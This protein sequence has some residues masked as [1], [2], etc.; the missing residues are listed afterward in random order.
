MTDQVASLKIGVDGSDAK[1]GINEIKDAVHGIAVEADKASQATGKIGT[2]AVASTDKATAAT[3]R[4]EAQLKRLN[5][6]L[7]AGGKNTTAYIEGRAKLA[8][9]DVAALAPLIKRNQELRDVQAL[10][11]AEFTKSGKA[12]TEY[13]MGVKATSAALR[14]V[15]AQFTDIIVSLQG[16]QA[17]LT[18][19][20][21]QGGQLKDV[22]GGVGNAFKA[23]SSYV[24]GLVNPFTIAAGVAATL[25]AAFYKG[26]AESEAY[27]KSLILT[28]NAAG[29]TAGRL[30]TMA[31]SVSEASGNTTA[32]VAS[33]MAQLVSAGGVAEAQFKRIA[34]TAASFERVAGVAV[35]ETVKQF[36]ELGKDPVKASEKLNESTHYLTAEI[37]NQIKALEDQGDKLGAAAVAQR[38]YADALD[39]RIPKLQD[40]LGL[41][42]K[43]WKGITSTAKGAWDAMLGI[44]RGSTTNA[45]LEKAQDQYNN[46]VNTGASEAELKSLAARVEYYQRM[47]A[48]EGTVAA[49]QADR[50]KRDEAGI[51]LAKE[52]DKYLTKEEK[53]RREMVQLRAEYDRSGKTAEDTANFAKAAAGAAAAFNGTEKVKKGVDEAAKGLA[54][55]NDLMDKASGFEANWAENANL[56]RKA[57]DAKKI[58]QEQFDAAVVASY[59]RQPGYIAAEKE[60]AAAIKEAAKSYEDAAKAS[61]KYYEGMAKDNASLEKSNEKLKEEVEAIGMSAAAKQRLNEARSEAAIVMAQEQLSMLNLQNSSELEIQQATRRVELLKEE[62]SLRRQGVVRTEANELA[63][64]NKKAAEESSKYWEDALMRAFESG[65]GFFESLWDTIKN[66]LKTQVLKVLVTGTMTGLAGAANATL[67]SSAGSAV[68]SLLGGAATSAGTGTLTSL[69]GSSSMGSLDIAGFAVGGPAGI[70]VAAAAAALYA[71]FGN[72][73]TPSAGTGEGNMSFDAS[74]NVTGST[75]R[76]SGSWGLT[77]E[78]EKTLQ[79]LSTSYLAAAKSLGIGAVAAEFGYGGNTGKEGKDPQFSLGVNAGGVGYSSGEIKLTDENVQ[80]AASRAILAALQGSEVPTYLEGVFDDLTA[81]T[82]T[83][84]Q[85]TAVLN[86]A[87]AYKDFHTAL[88]AMP[89]DNLTNMS[90][91]AAKGLAEA[92]GGLETLGNNL[93][94]FYENFYS[95]AEQTANLTRALGTGFKSLGLTMP[96]DKLR[97]WYRGQVEAALALDQSIPANAA[98]TAGLLSMQSGVNNLAD[99]AETAAQRII[100]AAAKLEAE[101]ISAQDSAMQEY[102]SAQLEYNSLIAAE[103]ESAAQAMQAAAEAIESAMASAGQGIVAFID[104]LLNTPANAQSNYQRDLALAQQGD[105]EA[106]KRLPTSGRAYLDTQIN[107]SATSADARIAT[108]RMVAELSRLPAVKSYEQQLLEAVGGTTKAVENLNGKLITELTVTARSEITKLINFVANTDDLPDD[109]KQLALGAT[110]T[111]TKTV[112]YVLGSVLS[113]DMQALALEQNSTLTKTVRLALGDDLPDETKR[114]VLMAS[115]SVSKTIGLVAFSTMTADQQAMV[116]QTTGSIT[117]TISLAAGALDQ[118]ALGVA[119]AQSGT[120][121]R[122][123]RASGG[124]LTPEQQQLLSAVDVY[125]KTVNIDVKLD[126]TELTA[127]QTMLKEIFGTISIPGISGDGVGGVDLTDI[128]GQAYLDRLESINTYIN[129]LDWSLENSKASAWATYY[130]AQQYGVSQADIANATGLNYSDIQALFDSANV[131]RFAMGTNYLP[132]DML[133]QVHQGERI[134]PAADNRELMNRLQDPQQNSVALVAEIKALRDDN[135]AQA[136]AMVQL[137]QR[138]TKLM[139]RWDSNG[140]PSQRI[141]T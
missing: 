101:I 93:A 114:I 63:K 61:I 62:A 65:K 141:E 89:W 5:L 106:S 108:A 95:D 68:G 22:F 10:A 16:G 59:E 18:V 48:S 30:S 49:Y 104:S 15:P 24:L 51:A 103:Q 123:V 120:I 90:Y 110:S 136:R 98:Y 4:Y 55:Y 76:Y 105:V 72:K 31:K 17:P 6:E 46:A 50:I 129:S 94:G 87:K 116:L 117:K 7:E 64:A 11:N 86:N 38:A 126:A 56:L 66:T 99:S 133:A 57:L 14:Q 80:L 53:F 34:D 79:N 71:I 138:L 28:G 112:E 111:F 19:L 60:R 77:S 29:T 70:A 25:G 8:G 125:N 78:V 124:E 83:Q 119:F 92:S 139:E 135:A 67:G 45:L 107:N 132:R 88:S 20:L 27:N 97:E 9:A 39:D 69:L 128:V 131:P 36:S 26:A 37:Y 118:V 75:S 12:L 81:S 85:I 44:G 41:L 13:G 58:S 73:K 3:A 52:R 127:F 33:V 35:A 122:I 113:P 40:N 43:A 137:Q 91:K 32:N 134:I 47:I 84:D 42:E 54:L 100:D 23:L 2:G 21:Q 74:G 1:R 96:T 109:L 130:A 115:E 140:V 121:E 82:A 102:M